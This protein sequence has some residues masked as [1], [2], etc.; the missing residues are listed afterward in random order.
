M[1]SVHLLVK[2]HDCIIMHG[3]KNIKLARLYEYLDRMCLFGVEQEMQQ[4]KALP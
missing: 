2:L 4:N 3:T 1:K